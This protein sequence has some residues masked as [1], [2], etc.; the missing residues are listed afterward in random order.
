MENFRTRKVQSYFNSKKYLDRANECSLMS[1]KVALN[2]EGRHIGK[3]IFD[4]QPDV[5]DELLIFAAQRFSVPPNLFLLFK[6]RIIDR[7]FL[8]VDTC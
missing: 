6:F 8:S 3:L 5:T 4:H 7:N 2:L 1:F